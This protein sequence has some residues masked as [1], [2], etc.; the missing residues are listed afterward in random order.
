MITMHNTNPLDDTLIL[1]GLSTDTKPLV[2]YTN[3]E[4]KPERTYIIKNGSIF[5]DI[6]DK[7]R[8]YYDA[9]NQKWDEAPS[10][11]GG[12]EPSPEDMATTDEVLDIVDGIDWS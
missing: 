9:E 2:K 11:G 10:G 3:T 1:K 7:K 6:D 8:Y 4:I 5:I 12:D